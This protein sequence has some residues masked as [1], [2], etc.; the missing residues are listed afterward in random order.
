MRLAPRLVAVL[1]W[2]MATVGDPLADLGY[3]LATWAEDGDEPNPMLDLSR[4]TRQP[5]FPGRAELAARYAEATGLGLDALPW[6]EVLALWK[7]AIF[8]EGSYKR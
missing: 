2:E 3:C 1:D 6:Y 7:S 8:L 5:G 4:A